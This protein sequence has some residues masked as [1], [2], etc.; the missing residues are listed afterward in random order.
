[1]IASPNIMMDAHPLYD[2][3]FHPFRQFRSLDGKRPLYPRYL[4]SQRPVRYYYID[5]GYAKWFRREDEPRMVVGWR[6]REQTPEQVEGLPYDPFRADVFQLGAI[7]RRDLIPVRHSSVSLLVAPANA[8]VR[9]QNISALHFLLPLA[10]AMTE[11]EPSKRP[12]LAHARQA[13]NVHFAGLDGW[14]SRWPIVPSHSTTKQRFFYYYAGVT[15]EVVIFLRRLLR[16][17]VLRQW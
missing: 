17:V 4:R 14:R 15:T 8:T 7:I 6:A 2:E 3:P 12:S 16:L 9:M 11:E 1:D 10:R 5:F 13:M